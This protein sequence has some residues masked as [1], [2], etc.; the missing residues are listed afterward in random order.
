MAKGGRTSTTW[1]GSSWR[2]GETRTIRVP[3]A[4]ADEIMSYA[5]ALDSGNAVSQ[6]NTQENILSAIANYILWRGGSRHPNQHGKTVDVSARTWDELRK[7][8]KLV[9]EQPELLGLK[10]E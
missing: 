7:F 4:L 5:R 8:A 1:T 3:A 9:E 10:N 2:H 6:G